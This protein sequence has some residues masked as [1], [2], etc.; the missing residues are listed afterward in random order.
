MTTRFTAKSKSTSRF[1]VPPLETGYDS[2]SFPNDISIPSCGL[3]DVDRSLFNLFNQEIPLT[4]ETNAGV[5]RVPIVL[6]GGEKWAIL[7]KATPQDKNGTLIIP[8]IV[9]GRN[10]ITQNVTDDITGRGINQN[11]GTLEIKRRLDGSNRGY[12]SLI[13]RLYLRNQSNAAVDPL[14]ELLDDQIS[15]NREIGD[16]SDDPYVLDGGLLLPDRTNE[17]WETLVIPQPQ[18]YTATYEVIIWTQYTQQ[19]NSIVQSIITSFLPQGNCWKLE[20]NKGYW[21]VASIDGNVFNAQNNF[22]NMATEERII[23]YQFTVTVPAYLLA[24]ETPG[25]PVAV[26]RY[27]SNPSISFSIS[28]ESDLIP[29]VGT[30]PDVFLGAD[31][32][33]LPLA[34]RKTKRSDQRE[35][36]DSLLYKMGED[37]PALKN[38]TRNRTSNT[39][40]TISGIDGKGKPVKKKV[41]VLNQNL[42]SG[43]TV[44]NSITDLD[45]ISIKSFDD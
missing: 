42:A 45:G 10:N 35:T 29:E 31:D 33:T 23:K 39:Y 18:F 8:S 36:N 22:E 9:I 14:D 16:L 19:M 37:D 4:V 28:S 15:T 41:K 32:P 30:E 21:F 27:V 3:E 13:N 6:A 24:G 38:L 44:Y 26:R 5:K 2:R 20:T 40:R 1:G 11:T 17:I 7:R 34:L 43:E 25:Q 12:Q